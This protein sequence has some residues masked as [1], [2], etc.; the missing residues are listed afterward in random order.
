MSRPDIDQLP[1]LEFIGPLAG[2]PDRR[3][4]VLVELE[5]SGL[6]CALRSL[7]DDALRFLV[8]PPGPFFPDYEPELGTD[9]ARLLDLQTPQDALVLTIITPGEEAAPPTANL[10]A[11]V[12]INVR[13]RKAAQIIL[14]DT[15]LPLRAPL[16]VRSH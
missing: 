3:L 7:D 10:F 2:F 13:T 5:P 15:D 9:W 1:T 14:D 12:I 11:P 8:A 16:P 6:L 4:F